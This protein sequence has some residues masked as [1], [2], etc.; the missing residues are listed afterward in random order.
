MF[1]KR[2][3]CHI[4]HRLW[5][6]SKCS[7]SSTW[8]EFVAI[9]FSLESFAQFLGGFPR[10]VVYRLISRPAAEIVEVGSM[11]LDLHELAVKILIVLR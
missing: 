7:K 8:R 3:S 11:K 1:L 6:P 9:D 10:Q 5:G 4:C 2:G